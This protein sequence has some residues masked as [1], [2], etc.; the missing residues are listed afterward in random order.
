[1]LS[2]QPLPIR[3]LSSAELHE[4][5]AK[6]ICYNCDQK[7]SSGHRC[8][9]QYLLLLGTDDEDSEEQLEG[10]LTTPPEPGVITGDISSLNALAGQGNPRS[11]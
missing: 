1:M 4:K 8:R 2:P 6:G 3:R 5:R 10:E 11:L 7:W 9:S